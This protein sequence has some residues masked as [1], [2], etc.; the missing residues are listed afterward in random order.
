MK[1]LF[2]ASSL[3]VPNPSWHLMKA[4]MEDVL[5]S[6]IEIHAIQR[7]RSDATMPP[8]PDRI[9]NHKNFSYTE[10]PCEPI[11]KKKF[12]LPD[13]IKTTGSL[14]VDIKLHPGIVGKLKIKVI[15]E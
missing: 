11:D 3:R 5:D 14:T 15:S 13:G 12:V 6:G 7:H 9:L 4:L 2:L 1:I 10:V 8:F